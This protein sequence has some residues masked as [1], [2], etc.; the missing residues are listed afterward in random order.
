MT[1]TLTTDFNMR[2][3][4]LAL[5]LAMALLVSH[6]V[7]AATSE[8]P[9]DPPVDSAPCFAAITASNDDKIIADCATLISHDKTAKSDRIRALLARAGAFQ[10]KDQIDRAIADDDAL[11]RL[12]PSADVFNA[13]GELFRKQGSRPRALGDFGAALKLDRQHAA[14]RANYKSLAL[15]LEQIGADMALKSKAG[16]EC[17]AAAGPAA[18]DRAILAGKC[19]PGGKP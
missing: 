12:E 17:N 11:L 1:T 3:C 13:R 10:R 19:R 8:P 18:R 4:R 15:E 14:A 5:I 7:N 16:T 6:G 9:A 2:R